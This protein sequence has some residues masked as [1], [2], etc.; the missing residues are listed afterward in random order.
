V[1]LALFHLVLSPL[2]LAVTTWSVRALGEPVERAARAFPGDVAGRD[3][4]AVNAPDYLLDV[5]FVPSLLPALGRPEPRRMR[6]L[7]A[8]PVAVVVTRI[9]ERTIVLRSEPGFFQGLLGRLFRDP[10]RPL[11]VG[12]EI[13][14]PGM[15]A[16]VV[17]LTADGQPR[18][19][20]FRF[21]VPLEDPSLYWLRWEGEGFVPFTPPAVGQRV[22]LPAPASAFTLP[23]RRGRR[24]S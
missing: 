10:G 16:R 22:E 8:G 1:V 2:V 9:D 15:S 5:T 20:E 12:Q 21:T 14:L 17:A 18:E 4:V 3:V 6:G 7:T 23:G 19:A 11:Q 24:N 13:E